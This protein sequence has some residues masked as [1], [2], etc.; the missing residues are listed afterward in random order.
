MHFPAKGLTTALAHACTR[1]GSRKTVLILAGCAVQVMCGWSFYKDAF[2]K[3]P[4]SA[5]ERAQQRRAPGQRTASINWERVPLR[6][7]IARVSELFDRTVFI[8]RRVDPDL[9]ITLQV[10]TASIDQVLQSVAD[11]LSLGTSNLNGLRYLGPRHSAEQ[12]RTVAVV[13]DEAIALLP[14]ADRNNLQRK[15][16]LSWPRLSEPRQ[17]VGSVA[18][19]RGWQLRK[20]ELIP[21]DLWNAGELPELSAAEQLT[22]LLIGFDLTFKT[23]PKERALEIIRLEEVTIRREYRLPS[24]SA[25]AIAPLRQ[26]LRT[27]KSV[28]R[29]ATR[30][31][32]DARVEQHERLADLFARRPSSRPSRRPTSQSQRLYTLRV[33]E[34]PV[35]AILKQLAERLGWTVEFDDAAIRTA[36][37]SADARVSFS[38]EDSSE[39][40]LLDAMLRPAGLSYRREGELLRIVP[41][42]AGQ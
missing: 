39:E 28:R 13:R 32:V 4:Q 12:L 41:R 1:R 19:R 23:L 31:I 25:D 22:V 27:A 29:E 24:R 26:E 14:G 34:Q 3:Q 16:S 42:P 11:A 17:L 30:V 33:Q 9:R 40:E 7:A 36:G 10:E 38:V 15:S 35:S 5:R 21:H 6:D 2:A 18:Q 37:L 20:S 8:D